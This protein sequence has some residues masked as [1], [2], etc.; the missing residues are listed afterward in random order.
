MGKKG[1]WEPGDDGFGFELAAGDY[2]EGSDSHSFSSTCRIEMFRTSQR[3][4]HSHSHGIEMMTMLPRMAAS[5][6]HRISCPLP[7][8]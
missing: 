2:L 6:R 4:N 1:G 7:R 5:F 3:R 8:N